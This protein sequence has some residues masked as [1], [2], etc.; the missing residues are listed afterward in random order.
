[1]TSPPW[2]TM[3]RFVVRHAGDVMADLP[4]KELGDQAPEYKRPFVSLPKQKEIDAE[5]INA[6]VG[7]VSAL[8]R[9]LATPDLCSK[10]W[11]WEQY[12]HDVRCHGAK[13]RQI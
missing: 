6:P 3:K 9:L 2:R 5:N 4:I 7:I 10:R 1:M 12:D 8:E 11:V 13:E